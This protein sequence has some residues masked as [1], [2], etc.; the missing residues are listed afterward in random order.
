MSALSELA[1]SAFLQAHAQEPYVQALAVFGARWLIIGVL[2][3][4]FIAALIERESEARHAWRE[5]GW[6]MGVAACL[7]LALALLIGRERPFQEVASGVMAWIPAPASL[8]SFPSTHSAM[9]WAW[10]SSASWLARSYAW[11]WVLVA[12]LISLSRVLVGV[13]YLSDVVGGLCIG[14]LAFFLV[15]AGH[16]FTQRVIA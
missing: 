1:F 4:T 2:L 14:V 11:L 6:S 9:A 16:R 3:A 7:S 8:H 5:V 12:A 13:H 10:A 15:R